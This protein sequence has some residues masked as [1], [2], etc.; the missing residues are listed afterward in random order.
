VQE[1]LFVSLVQLGQM[2]VAA[3]FMLW[4]DWMLFL[5][6]LGLVPILWLLNRHFNRQL[7]R[8][9]RAVQESFSRVT[10]TLAE[11]VNG[12][13]VT[14]SFARQD[15]NAGMFHELVSDH[16]RHNFELSQT[17]SL[18][19]RLLDLNNQLF[20]GLLL[21]VGAMRVLLMN[22]S[23]DVGALVGFL[24]MAS[25]FFAPITSLGLQYNHALTAMAG[26]ERVFKVLDLPTEQHD[27]PDAVDV[28]RVSGRIE[29]RDVAF[30][31]DAGRPV[32]HGLNFVAQ[33]GQ[34][35]ALVGHTG[36]GKT[37]ILNLIAK[38]Y[39][40]DSGQILIDGRDLRSI[41]SHSL[42]R[43]L[44]I[45]SQQNFLFSGTVRDNIRFSR[46]EATDDEV[47]DVVQRLD[48]FDLLAALP[49]GLETPVG[50]CGGNLSVGTRQLVC[51]AR[52]LLADPAILFLDE[53]TAS[54]DTLTEARI[55]R[56]LAILLAGRT[57][58]VVAH[59]LSTIR[60]ADQILVLDAGHIIQRGTHRQLLADGGVYAGLYRRFLSIA[61]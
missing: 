16:S 48:C 13:R 51:F 28:P 56:A 26:A 34:S 21:F 6:V 53:A 8:G 42:R 47:C 45:V 11:S 38:F 57:S 46:P 20:I 60:H 25:L 22:G 19:Q 44:G 32:L 43:R 31:Y 55:Q 59:R 50:Q 12:I 33:P 29:F 5:L 35:I 49:W 14:Q 52:A 54:V 40:P 27:A 58:F 61:A 37:S 41:R 18:F 15:T 39:L 10:A 23:C 1:V 9:H 36:S 7:S 17:Q 24:F 2:F 30:S 3:L 4:Y